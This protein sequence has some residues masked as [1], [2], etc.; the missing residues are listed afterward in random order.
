MKKLISGFLYLFIVS[1]MLSACGGTAQKSDSIDLTKNLTAD[2]SGNII[3]GE[4]L[5]NSYIKAAGFAVRLFRQTLDSKGENVLVSPISVLSAL[6]M[7]ANGA[8][9]ETLAQMEETFGLSQRE[10]S[11]FMRFYMNSLENGDKYKLNFAN[12][13]WLKDKQG[14]EI[15]AGFL[16]ANK[17][18]YDASIYKSAFDSK[19]LDDIN[20]WI[21][22]ETDGLIKNVLEEI[23][24]N[25]IMYLINALVFDAEWQHIY[26][27]YQV[28]E[29][30]FT[31]ADGKEQA[32]DFMYSTEAS[33]LE[34]ENAAGFI[35]YYSGE[36]YAFAALL[37]NE[38]IS[39]SEYLESLTGQSLLNI[40][41][42]GTYNIV[43][44]A[45]PK[46]EVEFESEM[47]AI[48]EKMGITDAFYPD[49]ADFTAMGKSENGSIYIS[50]VIHKTY[51]SVAEKGT[52]AG[53]VTIVEMTDGAAPIIDDIKV[54]HLDRPFVYMII[55][56]ET[57]LPLFIGCLDS[58]N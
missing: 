47:S 28:G 45:I 11:C 18:F 50:S 26:E 25:A 5:E 34:D 52:K 53:A 3:T 27:E 24:P 42:G 37:P 56:T 55:D 2:V 19:T 32:A 40:L 21:N 41:K 7:T 12:S 23:P 44:A 33:Y 1:F 6:G 8:S 9:G 13:I 14:L 29:G 38:G 48:L 31:T 35:K 30:T 58:L 10:L 16:Q 4:E 46:F 20:S 22:K 51:I 15:D 49:L 54:I 17:N 36:K 39:V 43:D 57:C